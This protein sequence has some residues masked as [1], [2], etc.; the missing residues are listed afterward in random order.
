MSNLLE[1]VKAWP[2]A[3]GDENRRHRIRQ[4]V[5]KIL[6][7]RA[8]SENRTSDHSEQ[9]AFNAAIAA[10]SAT[11]TEDDARACFKTISLPTPDIAPLVFLPSSTWRQDAPPAPIIWRDHEKFADA[12]LS[13]GDVAVLA[14]A[15]KGGKSY[16]CVALAKAAA[17]PTGEGYGKTCGLR[18]AARPVV[19]LSYEDSPKRIDM[20]AE[21]MGAPPDAVLVTDS[22][23][24]SLYGMDRQTRT[25]QPSEAWRRTWDGIAA[26]KPGLVVIDTGPKAMH[27]ETLD[28]GAIIGFLQ[29]LENE[30]KAGSFGVL[31]TAHDTK[32]AR[33]AA[34]HGLA[35][36]AGVIAGSAQWHDS[37]R[38]VLHLTKEGPG[39]SPRILEA[40]KCSY[41]RD[42]WGA[43]LEVLYNEREVYAGLKLKIHLDETG[44][45]DAREALKPN[46]PSGQTAKS[47]KKKATTNESGEARLDE[48]A[49]AGQNRKEPSAPQG[50]ILADR[51]NPPM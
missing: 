38:G 20:R 7:E 25:W 12:V 1:L 39:D 51:S 26:C 44:V 34:R 42:G 29:E 13:V 48:S 40:I 23:P 24:P 18:I 47:G 49:S 3:E 11:A 4:E 32:V 50:G 15:G 36:D 37:P 45:T 31:I 27:G 35:V 5:G 33:D 8:P 16:L 28:P 2:D 19:I 21:A 14:G 9:T 46:P 43:R 30:A 22:R 41:G 17:E 6:S 10:A